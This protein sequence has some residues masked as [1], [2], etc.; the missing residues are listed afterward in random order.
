MTL[1]GL[2]A[3]V[4]VV[5]DDAIVMVENIVLHLSTGDSAGRR[6]QEGH[7]RADAGADRLD[8][9]ARSWSS[10]RW[11][12]WAASRPSSSARWRWPSSRRCSPRCFSPSSS[13]PCSP[14]SFC[15]PREGPGETDVQ[16]AEQ[17]GGGR[18]APL[19]HGPL[20]ARTALVPRATAAPVLVAAVLVLAASVALYLASSAAG[21]CP[22]WTRGP[23]CSTTSRRPAPRSRRRTACSWRS[24]G[25]CARRRRSRATRA[26][27]GAQLGL[28]I[29]EPN[30]GD[31]LVKLK[32]ERSRSLAEVTSELRHKIVRAQPAI[33]VEFPHILED[34][35]GDLAYS[36]Q[37]IEIKVFH[38]ERGGLQAGGPRGRGMAAEGQGRGRRGESELRDRAGRELP[39][40]RRQGPAPRLRG[41]RR[42]QPRSHHPRRTGGLRHDSRRPADRH[43]RALS[44]GLSLVDRP[45]QGAA[46]HLAHRPDGAALAASP[47]SRWRK[48]R[49][50]STA[51]TCATW[52][53]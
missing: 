33:D 13:R 20:R 9:H 2:A 47:T 28:S 14:A 44:R 18:V 8:P 19:A 25:S 30:T 4:G 31:F 6:G 26:A 5:I 37:P 24:R 11:C 45:A 38:P 40:R 15:R 23:S 53:R 16:K 34:L 43:S 10:H 3:A 51:R 35:I 50:R 36:P 42:G 29:A 7:P 12:S 17:A 52:P 27:P 46:R 49:R 1:G 41:E 39:R 22:R 21:S 48:G 32:R